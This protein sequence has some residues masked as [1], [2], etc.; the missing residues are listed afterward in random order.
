MIWKLPAAIGFRP[1][2]N[3]FGVIWRLLEVLVGLGFAGGELVSFGTSSKH[4]WVSGWRCPV[5]CDVE[6]PLNI[7]GSL[8]GGEH[9]EV[10]WRL[11]EVVVYL[12]LANASLSCFGGVAKQIMGLGLAECSLLSFGS[13]SKHFLVS[14]L[15]VSF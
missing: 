8:V 6:A 11:F 9:F 15:R 2:G 5:L 7:C 3:Q 4:M 12:G 1:G 14:G 10:I 13:L